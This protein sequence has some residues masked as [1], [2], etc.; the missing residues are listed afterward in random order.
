MNTQLRT[1]DTLFATVT[2]GGTTLVRLTLSG[3]CSMADVMKSICGHLGGVAG[4]V[5]VELRNSTLG[6]LQR[7]S[8]RLRA[9]THSPVQLTLF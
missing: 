2:S 8:L 6:W 4:I 5:T 1:T 9:V 3:F 7:R